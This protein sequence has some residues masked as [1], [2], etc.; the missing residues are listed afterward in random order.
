M[1]VT[2]GRVVAVVDVVVGGGGGATVVVDDAQS[3][4]A[5]GYAGEN[6]TDGYFE[7]RRTREARGGWFS[8]QLKVAPDRPTTLVCAYRGSEGRRRAF[9]IL[10]DGE[11][12]AAESLEY[13]PTE[14]LD[15]EYAVP[16]ALTRGKARV[17]VRFQAQPQTTAGAVIEVRTVAGSR[18]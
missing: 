1:V 3:E 15:R 4:A 9:D 12:V 14:R 18:L 10:V 2:S 8:Y 16:E 17:T 7:G 13:H 6:A 5:H 11:R